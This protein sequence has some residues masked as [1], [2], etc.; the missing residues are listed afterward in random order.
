MIGEPLKVNPSGESVSRGTT[1]DEPGLS[2]AC[3]PSNDEKFSLTVDFG[4]SV[5]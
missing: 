1:V 5:D 4:A 2:A 3:F